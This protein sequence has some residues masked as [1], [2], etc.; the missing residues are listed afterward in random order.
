MA[1]TIKEFLKYMKDNEGKHREEAIA[2]AA[3]K[4]ADEDA[5]YDELSRIIEEHPIGAPGMLRGRGPGGR[6][7]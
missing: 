7:R 2:R 3:Q 5:Y 4:E 6:K 1:Y